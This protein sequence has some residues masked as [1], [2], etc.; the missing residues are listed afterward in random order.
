MEI[1]V[2]TQPTT[3]IEEEEDESEQERFKPLN[4]VNKIQSIT[5]YKFHNPGPLFEAFK[6]Y[7]YKEGNLSFKRFEILGDSFL[8]ERI[9][10]LAFKSHPDYGSDKLTQFRT[11]NV[12]NDKLARVALKHNLH[13]YLQHNIPLLDAQVIISPL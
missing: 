8:E 2:E 13:E 7:S 10:V 6:N 3:K 9:A 4:W 1:Q 12:D 5:G 11:V